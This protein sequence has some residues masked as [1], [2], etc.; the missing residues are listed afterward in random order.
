MRVAICG[1][2][3]IGACTAYFLSLRGIEVIVIER[4][5][6]AAAA[7]GKAGGFLALD[8]CADTPL[9]ALARRSF[10]L[11]AALRD[12]VAGDW[13]YRRGSAYSGFVVDDRDVRRRV[14][15]DLSWLSEDVFISHRLGTPETT[16]I[17]N[18]RKFTVAMMNAARDHG[19]ELRRGQVTGVVQCADGSTVEG[20]E[21][22]GK[23]VEADAIVVAM[24]PWSLLAAEWM[25]LPA[26]FG[27]RSPSVVYDT[28]TDVPPEALFLDYHEED[29]SV[30]TVE[31]FP[32]ADGSTHVTPFSDIVP[33]PLD[34]ATVIPDASVIDRLE[35]TC[36]RLS[37]IFRPERIVARQAC[38]RPVTQDGLPLIGK[39]PLSEVVYVAT[40]HS[41]WGILNGPATGEA[42]A[43]LIAEGVSSRIDLSPF[44]P[45]R[46]QLLRK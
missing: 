22:D 35:A 41:V 46:F 9:D 15:A 44:D 43:E 14:P 11:H 7:S 12:R 5:E 16:A 27:Q 33:L 20:V 34:P 2:G 40:G 4:A 8:W 19:A 30:S 3:V 24:G 25:R 17:V 29:G 18:P 32:R 37:P 31:V 1:G 36:K 39:V 6:V 10:Q 26:V 38:F 21:V 45:M 28:G 42:L 23:L 13:G